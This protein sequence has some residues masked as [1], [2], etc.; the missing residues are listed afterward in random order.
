MGYYVGRGGYLSKENED[1]EEGKKNGNGNGNGNGGSNGGG[2]GGGGNGGGVSENTIL[3][4]RDGK[5]AKDKGYS[6]RDWFKG[7]G[8]K[9]TGGKYDG[10]P[11]ARQPGQKTKPFCRDA[12]D[13]ASMS[14]DERNR[15]ALLKNAEKI[16]IPIEKERQKW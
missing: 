4:K 10:K 13:R 1:G 3:E 16:Q 6:L 7:G 8:W 9:Q 12:D 14:K 2:N 11:C 15:R 5:S